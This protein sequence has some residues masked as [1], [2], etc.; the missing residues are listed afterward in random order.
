MY[1]DKE[2]ILTEDLQNFNV[3]KEAIIDSLCREEYITEQQANTIKE[4]YA[5]VLVKNNWFGRTIGSL[6]GKKDTQFI[7]VMKVV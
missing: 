4:N 7:K 3:V 5:V 1:S 2:F 6:L